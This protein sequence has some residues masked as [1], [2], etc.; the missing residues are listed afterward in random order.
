M[1]DARYV[2]LTEMGQEFLNKDY[3][4]P[5]QPLDD[6][7][8]VIANK[9]EQDL[10]IDGFAAKFVERLR[11][12]W[13]S[14]A[15]PVWTNYGNSRGLPISCYGSL[16]ED[17]TESILSTHC[18]V[19]MMSKYGGG[20]SAFFGKIRPRNSPITNNGVSSG[21][22][23]FMQMFESMMG[24]ISQGS[25]R[26][27][28]FV[29]WL[30]IDHGDIEEFLSIR[31]EGS[32]LQDISFGVTVPDWWLNEMIDGDKAKRKIWAKVIEARTK[33]GYPYIMFSDNVNK[34]SPQVYR[35][36]GMVITHSNLCSEICLAD[37]EFE[38]FVCDLSSMNLLHY[39]DW[40]D[41][42]AVEM[43]T[44]FLDAVMTEFIEKASGLPYMEKAVLFAKN[45]RA[46]GIGALGYHSL[47]QK[48]MIAFESFEAKMLNV[49]IFK[50]IK[51][52]STKASRDMAILYG[53]PDLLKGYG[54]RNVTTMAIAPTKSSAFILGQ[55]SEGIEPHK[56]NYFIKDLAKGKFTIR[57]KELEALLE[58]KGKNNDEIWESILKNAG[59]V[60]HLDC[61]S[62]H[63]KNVFKTFAEISMKEVI[64]QA[65]A[66]QNFIDQAQSLNVMIHPSVPIKEVNALYLDAW[67]LG[68]KTLYYQYNVNAA[69]EFAKNINECVSCAS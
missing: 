1:L 69:K 42:D 2:W 34:V 25:T 38:S 50:L 11:K 51:E 39:H 68:V 58:S 44:Y 57:N 10:G 61:L 54:L 33:V 4:M 22:V 9:A 60:Q 28:Q 45:Q 14:L 49:E 27:G 31:S 62:S 67:K 12:G 63:E 24:V 20:T 6:R 66:R 46:L 3:L 32:P 65:A 40:K 8:W 35:D 64:I 13:Y 16:I 29:T 7:V 5:D 36:K 23:H 48:H 56:A 26:R 41:T 55:V 15:T 30:N 43:L 37:T 53:E 59:S 19:G 47:L 21:S 52:K 18:E 17:R